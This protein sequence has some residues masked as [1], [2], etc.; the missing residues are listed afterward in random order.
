MLDSV[1]CPYC[2]AKS[3][4]DGGYS[5]TP[6][7]KFGFMVSHPIIQLMPRPSNKDLL[8]NG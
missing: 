3:L 5:H 8:E 7:C 6:Y 4:P 2:G 1:H